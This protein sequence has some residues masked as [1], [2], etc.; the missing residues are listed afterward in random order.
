M[1]RYGLIAFVGLAATVTS[2]LP[3]ASAQQQT[4][5]QAI[6]RTELQRHDLGIPGREAVQVRVDFSPGAITPRHRHPGEELVFVLRGSLEVRVEGREP[7]TLRPGDT[8]FIPSGAAH[9]ARN[10]G[11]GGASVLATY[12]VEK[13]RPLIAPAP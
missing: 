5:P 2:A 10:A 7:V 12:V 6:G 8:L 3:A 13:G 11:A 1:T 9:D 4:Q